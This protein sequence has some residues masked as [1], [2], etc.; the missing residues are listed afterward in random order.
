MAIVSREVVCEDLDQHLD[1][2]DEMVRAAWKDYESLP[3]RCHVV[4]GARSRASNVHDF[5]LDRA[6]SYAA[7][8]PGVKFF[9][10]NLMHGIVIDGKYAIRFKKFDLDNRSKN[11][12]TQQVAEF[13]NQ[14]DLDGIDAPHHLEVGYV[15]DFLES[16]VLDV[17]LACPSGHGNAWVVSVSDR[18][19]AAVL[20]DLFSPV[21]HGGSEAEIEPA[22]IAPRKVEGEVVPFVRKS[23]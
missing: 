14:I 23:E 13:R 17:R 21:D 5:L 19:A 2:F 15:L 7:T 8:T 1:A 10:R 4:F 12:P 6:A 9:K 3:D 20:A 22:D 18:G 16:E 11:Q